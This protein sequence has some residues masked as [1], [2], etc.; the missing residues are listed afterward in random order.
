MKPFKIGDRVISAKHPVYIVAEISANHGQSFRRAVALIRKAKECGADAVKFQA[1]TPET[2]T[3]DSNNK[4]FRVRH[5]QW[6]G[7]TLFSLYQKAYT[8]WHWLKKLKAVADDLALGFFATAFDAT[9]VDYLEEIDVP[10]HKIASF[11]LVDIPL[12]EYAARTGKPLIMSTGM[13]EQ[14]EIRDAVTAARRNGAGDIVLLKCVSN[15]PAEP[16]E[17][18]LRVIPDMAGR[19]G[20]PVGLS[21]HTLTLGASVAAVCLG[22][23]MIEKHFTLSRRRQT[24]DSFFST[25]P[26]EFKMLVDN[27]RIVEQALG[28]VTYAKTDREK[29]SRVFRRSL[30]A[31]T[32]IKRGELLT[33]DNVRSIRPA[34]G[35]PPKELRK[36]TGRR[37]AKN[38]RRGTPLDKEMISEP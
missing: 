38:I 10:V 30:F 35:L 18:N 29:Q 13:A 8:P 15:Y 27:I 23:V 33:A 25:E 20:V 11:E 3:I 5:P 9:S 16:G 7:Q 14:R 22:A 26:P 2:M 6:G 36:V 34:H 4:Y 21:D 12:I 32:D 37:A 31:V 1:Y 19:F 17:M 24:P 28:T